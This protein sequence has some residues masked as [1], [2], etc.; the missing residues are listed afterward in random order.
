MLFPTTIAGSLPKPEWLAEPNMLWAPWKSSGADLVRAKCDATVLALKLKED[1]GVDIVT[2]G[3]AHWL[4]MFDTTTGRVVQAFRLPTDFAYATSFSPDGK[5]VVADVLE[6]PVVGLVRGCTFRRWNAA[7]GEED[8]R[9]R[10][11]TTS[12]S[13]L[14][15]PDAFPAVFRGDNAFGEVGD[16]KSYPAQLVPIEV[17]GVSEATSVAAGS[18]DS[19]ALLGNGQSPAQ[20]FTV[21]PDPV[22]PA[23]TVSVSDFAG[24][25]NIG[26]EEMVTINQ[27]VDLVADIAGKQIGRKHISGPQGVRGRNSDNR[28]IKEKLR[29]EPSQSLRV[30]L[31]PT[32]QWIEAQLRRNSIPSFV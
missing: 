31:E 15:G 29:W 14:A 27:L 20:L 6:K 25:V 7:T 24:P 30:G 4:K 10:G 16:G 28:F 1:S 11:I 12:N 3:D 2:E 32:Y 18:G 5:W 13:T 9:A 8:L 17:T 21:N 23:T 19:L 26:S 22:P